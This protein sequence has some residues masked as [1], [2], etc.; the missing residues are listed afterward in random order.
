MCLQNNCSFL[1]SL[2]CP[3]MIYLPITVWRCI[4][5]GHQYWHFPQQLLLSHHLMRENRSSGFLTRSDTNQ[6]VQSQKKARSLEFWIY[7]EEEIYYPC[8]E[9]IGTVPLFLHRHKSGF[10]M[11]RLILCPLLSHSD[12]HIAEFERAMFEALRYD[13]NKH[14]STHQ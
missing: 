2:S 5:S 8:S 14:T 1:Q 13:M 10:L 4:N 9:N 3:L 6:S 12:S 11:T 7:V